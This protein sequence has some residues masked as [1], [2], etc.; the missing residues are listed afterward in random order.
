[1]K[2]WLRAGT[3][4]RPHGLDGSVHVHGAVPALLSPGATVL[5]AGRQR[6]IVRRAGHDR[7][8]I[9]RLEGCEDREAA[10]AL[11]GAELLV[12]R[13]DAPELSEDEWWVED[14][15]GC[16]VYDGELVVG[17]VRRVLALPSC[18]VLEVER[19]GEEIA[20]E[21]AERQGGERPRRTEQ[22]LVPLVVDAV[23]HVDIEAS[24]IEIDL[25]FLG[26]RG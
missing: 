11:N 16:A 17:R 22:L 4:G 12:A 13:V 9:I 6:R 24:R 2:E 19:S 3:I 8:V 21:S 5:A 23:R 20:R 10:R 14:L 18:E 1:M 15:E 25:K 26:E 7:R